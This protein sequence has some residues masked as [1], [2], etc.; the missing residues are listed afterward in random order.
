RFAGLP[1]ENFS[2]HRLAGT[3]RGVV[4]GW[5]LSGEGSAL[6]VDGSRDTLVSTGYINANGLVVWRERRRQWQH[7]LRLQAQREWGAWIARGGATWLNY[8]YDTKVVPGW[9]TFADRSD[10]QVSA[11]A[12]WRS[13]A[14]S[15]WLA[16]VRAGRQEQ[17]IVPLPNCEFEYSA[18]Y[19]RLAVGWEGRLPGATVVALSLGPDFRH[20]TGAI[21]P[22]VFTGGRDR[23]SLWVEGSAVA[24]PNA[25][26]TLTGKVTRMSWLSSTGQSALMD[27]SVE[28]AALWT[29]N[30]VWGV[31][32]TG[33]LH[34]SAYFPSLRDDRES[35]A[36]A[37]VS[38]KL[39]KSVQLTADALRHRGWNTLGG[40]TGRDFNRAVFSLGA[41]MRL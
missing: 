28:A 32:V 20:F 25:R 38:L 39:T 23:T 19:R 24:K 17:A 8:D 12:G 37:G 35:L 15:L 2:Q 41:A 27:T 10:R 1:A 3:G 36:G 11:D 33:K 6:F 9:L 29:L 14:T 40:L 22:R 4:G 26:C 7:R 13:S 21:D 31:R 16:G 30:P 18:N 5:T 34:E